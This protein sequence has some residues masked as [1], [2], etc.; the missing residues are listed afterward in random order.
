MTATT[1]PVKALLADGEIAWV[2]RLDA[3]DI[4]ELQALRARLF[5]RDRYL[6]FFEVGVLEPAELATRLATR[7]GV[8]P[9]AVGCFR[10][11]RL[12]GVA[13][14]EIVDDPAEAEISLIVDGRTST[15]GVAT[16]LLEQLVFA[17]EH[18][19]VRTFVTD[20]VTEDANMLGVFAALGIP[21]RVR[22]NTSERTVAP[23]L[24]SGDDDLGATEA[25]Q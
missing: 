25:R 20:V 16:L 8:G 9:T 1:P 18:E 10:H 5:G 2:R 7:S 17:A 24:G 6:R 14:Y 15:L 12:V 4:T 21:F 3:G 19:G 11:T 13:Q 23:A 22:Q